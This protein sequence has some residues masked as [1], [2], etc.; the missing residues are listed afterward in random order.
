M[1]TFKIYFHFTY[2]SNDASHDDLRLVWC[3]LLRALPA[4]ASHSPAE[5]LLDTT[6]AVAAVPKN[7]RDFLLSIS[8]CS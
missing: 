1:R 6:Y 7:Q 4:G 5:N 8:R 2:V 3:V